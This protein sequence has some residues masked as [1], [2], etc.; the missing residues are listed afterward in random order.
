VVTRFP[1]DSETTLDGRST[2]AARQA[3][4][5]L[6]HR[7][8]SLSHLDVWQDAES[9][10]RLLLWQARHRVLSVPLPLQ[11]GLIRCIARRAVRGV[12]RRELRYRQL[13]RPCSELAG[14]EEGRVRADQFEGEGLCGV[15]QPETRAEPAPASDPLTAIWRRIPVADRRLLWDFY[16]LGFRDRDLAIER[17]IT[18]GAAKARRQRVVARV[19]QDMMLSQQ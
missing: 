12:V 8:P 6:K 4:T 10:A 19:R 9:E 15:P 13:C 14:A 1:Q 5:V 18:P 2:A 11:D 3:V 7:Y 17:E 16:V